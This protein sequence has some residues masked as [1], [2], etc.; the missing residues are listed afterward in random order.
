MTIQE[1]NNLNELGLEELP[2]SL[3]AIKVKFNIFLFT[4][5]LILLF[6]GKILKTIRESMTLYFFFLFMFLIWTS[7]WFK[8]YESLSFQLLLRLLLLF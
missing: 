5:M 3:K 7:K 4:Q 1:E 6:W 8:G 2:S